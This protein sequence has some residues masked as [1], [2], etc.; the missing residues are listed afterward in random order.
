VIDQALSTGPSYADTMIALLPEDPLPRT[1]FAASWTELSSSSCIS[2]LMGGLD[3][4]RVTILYQDPGLPDTLRLGGA[5]AD[6]TVDEPERVVVSTENPSD[7]LLVLADTWY[8]RWMAFIDGEPSEILQA[9]HWQ[10]AVAVPAGSHEVE[11][12][13]DSGDVRTGMIISIAGLFSAFLITSVEAWLAR[14]RKK[15]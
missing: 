10:R 7:G 5:R 1:W 11:F 13:F 3:P 9:N 12:R 6:I 15:A 4:Q 2:L 8:P 14:R